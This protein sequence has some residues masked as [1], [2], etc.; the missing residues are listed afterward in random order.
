MNTY[1]NKEDDGILKYNDTTE[2]YLVPHHEEPFLT[3]QTENGAWGISDDHT[4]EFICCANRDEAEKKAKKLITQY[5]FEWIEIR[6]ETLPDDTDDP[7]WDAH[8]AFCMWI[9]DAAK[10]VDARQNP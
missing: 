2:Y 1:M 5:R 4:G 8:E 3:V 7:E 10:R 9:G 6:A